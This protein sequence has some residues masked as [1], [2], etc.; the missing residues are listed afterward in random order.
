MMPIWQSLQ[1][2]LY[3]HLISHILIPTGRLTWSSTCSA[4]NTRR[5]ILLCNS[6]S[7][8]SIGAKIPEATPSGC[9]MDTEEL[10]Q[11]Q[12]FRTKAKA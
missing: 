5:Q 3:V 8:V 12:D 9:R 1:R 11:K 6:S 7:A 4:S 2:I 10:D